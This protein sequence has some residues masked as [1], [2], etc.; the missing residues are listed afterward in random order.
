M[1]SRIVNSF[2]NILNQNCAVKKSH[3]FQ[4]INFQLRTQSEFWIISKKFTLMSIARNNKEFQTVVISMQM[5]TS[6]DFMSLKDYKMINPFLWNKFYFITQHCMI[7]FLHMKHQT[8]I[9]SWN[10]IFAKKTTKNDT[11]KYLIFT[12][13]FRSYYLGVKTLTNF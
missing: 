7:F 9:Q 1:L 11:S 3:Q 8:F 4:N 2:K 13:T 10:L 12:Y 5:L 6:S